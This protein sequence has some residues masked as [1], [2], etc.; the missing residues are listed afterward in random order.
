MKQLEENF[1]QLFLEHKFCHKINLNINLQNPLPSP[2]EALE[3][4]KYYK[5]L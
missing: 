2:S 1:L 5:K 4:E 3:K